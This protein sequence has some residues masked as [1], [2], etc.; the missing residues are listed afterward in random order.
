MT[1]NATRAKISRT[2]RSRSATFFLS[3]L[4][5]LSLPS[6]FPRRLCP[7]CQ[8]PFPLPSRFFFELPLLFFLFFPPGSMVKRVPRLCSGDDSRG[9]GGRGRATTGAVVGIMRRVFHA[10][11]WRCSSVPRAARGCYGLIFSSLCPDLP[12]RERERV[13]CRA[14]PR[15]CTHSGAPRKGIARLNHS[16]ASWPSFSLLCTNI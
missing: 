1:V 9:R 3:L 6:A 2:S 12:F 4:L 13:S 8:P 7:L 16:S 15:R 14:S 11:G 5:S 10:G